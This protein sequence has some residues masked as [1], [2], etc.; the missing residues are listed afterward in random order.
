M[1][2]PCQEQRAD[3]NLDFAL[4][5]CGFSADLLEELVSPY[6]TLQAYE[7]QSHF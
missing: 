4:S 6:I 5:S 2:R 1:V 7:Q 3:A